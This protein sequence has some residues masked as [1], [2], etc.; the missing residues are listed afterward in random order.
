MNVIKTD[1]VFLWTVVL[2]ERTQ[3]HT[4]VEIVHI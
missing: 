2:Q 1:I 4:K 3:R